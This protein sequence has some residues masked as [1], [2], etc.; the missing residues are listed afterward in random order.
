MKKTRLKSVSLELGLV[1]GG[2]VPIV[3]GTSTFDASVPC[4]AGSL[5][6]SMGELGL[7]TVEQQ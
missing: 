3:L 2:V 1:K 7:T 5:S 4:S 6:R